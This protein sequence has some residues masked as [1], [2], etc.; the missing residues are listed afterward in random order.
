MTNSSAALSAVCPPLCCRH[1]P[2]IVLNLQAE[3]F[4]DR[5]GHV[6]NIYYPKAG[7]DYPGKK[8]GFEPCDMRSF[9]RGEWGFGCANM[10]TAYIAGSPHTT[11][12]T[13]T[14]SFSYFG[15]RYVEVFGLPEGS[16]PSAAMLTAHVVHTDLPRVGSISLP[17]V[18]AQGANTS[19]TP[20]ILNRIH[21][22]A[23]NSQ[24]SNS[25]SIPTDCPT[26]ERLVR[27]PLA[28]PLRM[29]QPLSSPPAACAC[30]CAGLHGRCAICVSGND[31]HV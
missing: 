29:P 9:Y 11:R 8:E 3:L 12:P 7:A 26:R 27:N 6:M 10:S 20:D 16:R 22:A 18:T 14:P 5:A 28:S 31:V 30:A 2:A 21:R 1:G 13:W 15:F 4:D 17:N 24:L 19:G 25:W 23:I